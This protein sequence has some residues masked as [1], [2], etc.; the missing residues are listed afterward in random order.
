MKNLGFGM[1]RLP[2]KN[3]DPT[4]FNY[5]QLNRMILIIKLQEILLIIVLFNRRPPFTSVYNSYAIT[6]SADRL[7]SNSHDYSHRPI[8]LSAIKRMGR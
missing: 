7:S 2:V 5:E 8:V 1:M 4:D 6:L 3:G